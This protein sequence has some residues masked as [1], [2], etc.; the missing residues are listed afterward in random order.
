[1]VKC[2]NPE[3]GASVLE[4]SVRLAEMVMPRY[5]QPQI[6]GAVAGLQESSPSAALIRGWVFDRRKKKKPRNADGKNVYMSATSAP[7]Q[8]VEPTAFRVGI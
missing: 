6:P 7:S 2:P 5:R 3:E 8:T 1:M 4:L